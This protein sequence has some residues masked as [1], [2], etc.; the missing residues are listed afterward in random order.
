MTKTNPKEKAFE[1]LKNQIDNEHNKKGVFTPPTS[2]SGEK[3][4]NTISYKANCIS[5]I[6][7]FLSKVKKTLDKWEKHG[8]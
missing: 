5:Y 4:Y 1:K 2:S 6:T 3:L 7:Q 8:S